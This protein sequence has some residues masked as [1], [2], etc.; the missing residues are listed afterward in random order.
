MKKKTLKK[1]TNLDPSGPPLP[2]IFF[3]GGGSSADSPLKIWDV[4]TP[5]LKTHFEQKT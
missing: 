4:M 1:K 2:P 3:L 5:Y